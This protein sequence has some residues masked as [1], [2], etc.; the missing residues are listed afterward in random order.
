[1]CVKKKE[2]A[3]REGGKERGRKIEIKEK[4]EGGKEIEREGEGGRLR[5]RGREED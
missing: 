4:R 5:E 3:K 1:V 2:R